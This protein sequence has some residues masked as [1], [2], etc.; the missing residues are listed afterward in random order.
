[1]S[2]R[3]LLIFKDEIECAQYRSNDLARPHKG[4][5]QWLCLTCNRWCWRNDMC[6]LFVAQPNNKGQLP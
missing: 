6:N 5:K 4:S 2:D 3:K 1:M